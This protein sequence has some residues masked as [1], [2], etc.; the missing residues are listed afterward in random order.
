MNSAAEKLETY[1]GVL[2]RI[3][4]KP[5]VCELVGL[6]SSTVNKLEREGRFPRRVYVGDRCTGWR[7]SDLKKWFDSLEPVPTYDPLDE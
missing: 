4:F 5:E 1:D 3:I 6:G 2:D 7:L